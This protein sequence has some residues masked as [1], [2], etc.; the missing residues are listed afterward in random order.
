MIAE[1]IGWAPRLLPPASDRAIRF[2]PWVLAL[3]V[4]VAA[5]AGAGF[6][7]LQ[8]TLRAAERSLGTALTV[9]VPADTSGERLA[10]IMAVLRRTKGIESAHLFDA[11]ETQRL[12]EPW[13]GPA[14]PLDEMPVP[15]LIDVRIDPTAPP[16]LAT[17][18]HEIETVLPQA[19]LD[20]HRS[21]LDRARAAAR[22]VEALLAA[23]I[24]AALLLI[25]ASA[26]FAVRNALLIRRTDI[27]VLHLL[28]AADAAIAGRFA[29]RYLGFGLLGGAVGALAAIFTIA[30]LGHGGGVVQLPAPAAAKGI[31][32]WRFWAV[33]FGTAA[34]AG[35]IAMASAQLSVRR[36]LARMP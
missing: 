10:T 13:L 25:G 36:W 9:Q 7:L 16:Q 22:R 23:V 24:A 11:A 17:L 28:G 27:E 5:L 8:G 31:A 3:M 29:L 30:V 19:R 21:G 4:Y 26:T 2:L 32:D 15:R 35:L 34:V 33:T 1:R 18:R 6:I 14:A 20:D 12:L